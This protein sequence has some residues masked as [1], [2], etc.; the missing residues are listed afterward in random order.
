MTGRIVVVDTNYPFSHY[1][2]DEFKKYFYSTQRLL[3]LS[4]ETVQEDLKSMSVFPHDLAGRL[5]SYTTHHIRV[6]PYFI[7]TATKQPVTFDF[8]RDY[9]EQLIVH[10]LSGGGLASLYSLLRFRLSTALTRELEERVA[11]TGGEYSAIHI[12]HTDYVTEY[13]EPLKN[14]AEKPPNRLFLATDSRAV[15]DEF[16]ATLKNTQVFNFSMVLSQ[17]GKPIHYSKNIKGDEIFNRNQ[18][19]ILDLLMLALSKD[20]RISK[21]TNRDG[22]QDLPDYSGFS[23]LAHA[24][25]TSK[26]ILKHLLASSKLN[27]GL[28]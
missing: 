20:L 3:L 7:D 14:L 21:L 16:K 4:T 28:E 26:I 25:W 9:P 18:D 2:N 10:H 6:N 22:T 11:S 13:S 27:F 12:R 24:L 1:F 8:S 17:D 5:D 23:K 15:L 19:A